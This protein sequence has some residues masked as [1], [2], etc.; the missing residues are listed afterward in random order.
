MP[1]QNST[2]KPISLTEMQSRARKFVADWNG[3]SRER[4][5]AQSWWN[6]F[7][8]VF[9][10]ER[11]RLAIFERRARRASTGGDG[12]IDVFMPGVMIAEHKSLGKDAGKGTSQAFDYL[13]GGDIAAHEAPR[14]VISADFD[15]IVLTDLESDDPPL[16][17]QL[18]DLP[19]YVQRF[20]FLAGYEAPKRLSGEAEAVSIKAAREM[21]KLHEALLGDIE[22][23]D[24]SEA[25]EDAAIFMTRLL[26]LL[27]GDDVV[28]LWEPGL[29]ESYVKNRTS[30]DG[31][32]V[33]SAIATLFQV[34]DTEDR[35]KVPDEL[36]AFPYVNGG[37]FRKR[38]S[39]PF[40]DKKMR[41][42]LIVATEINWSD[43]SPAIFGSLFQGMSSRE[44][45][46]KSGSH[47]TTET[48]ILKVL[49]PLF[50][51]DLEDRLQ[52]WWWSS[53]ELEKLR[54][55]IGSYRYL[56]PACGAGAEDS[57]LPRT[58]IEKRAVHRILV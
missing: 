42:A 20:A 47:Y 27:Y 32:D 31:S 50:L 2:P 35:K 38:V 43:I 51:D 57:F 29:F 54:V 28:G 39:I 48:N 24:N 13:E 9:G 19:K 58:R 16:E 34:L 53:L 21:G 37:L 22:P 12:N 5:E 25:A 6:A 26:F 36:K 55:V 1:A 11:R 8:E 17:F 10:V 3:E 30:A 33:G 40:F 56:D 49:R 4:A 52:R 41:D 14:Y 23:D 15:R 46:R 18:R 45:R 7:F 44:E